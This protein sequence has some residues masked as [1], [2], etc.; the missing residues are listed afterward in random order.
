MRQ[1]RR[2]VP[3]RS[4]TD[5]FG[6]RVGLGLGGLSRRHDLVLGVL[7]LEV[8]GLR[9]DRDVDFRRNRLDRF[10]GRLQLDHSRLRLGRLLQDSRLQL[11]D[12]RIRLR[13]SRLLLDSRLQLDDNRIRPLSSRLLMNNRL[14]LPDDR[15]QLDDSRLHVARSRLF[16]RRIRL[17]RLH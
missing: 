15:L 13:G 8:L 1:R 10:R 2:R 9:D 12:S 17:C 4:G 14:R 11:D 5:E 16:R 3:V 6:L 7:R